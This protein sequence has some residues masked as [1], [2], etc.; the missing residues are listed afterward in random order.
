MTDTSSNVMVPG[1]CTVPVIDKWMT[2]TGAAGSANEYVE[3]GDVIPLSSRAILSNVPDAPTQ[4]SSVAQRRMAQ[5]G[6]AMNRARTG[7]RVRV[8]VQGNCIANVKCTSN[9]AIAA[10]DELNMGTLKYLD[11]SRPNVNTNRGVA[12]AVGTIAVGS[13]AAGSQIEVV[14]LGVYGLGLN[15]V[16][17]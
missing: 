3:A 15:G 12:R 6:V 5:V 17:A 4:A 10:G 1:A 7:T 13:S 11:A 2:W 8:R 16:G 9:V 14:M